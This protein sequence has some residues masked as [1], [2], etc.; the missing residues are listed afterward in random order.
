MAVRNMKDV[1]M[2]SNLKNNSLSGS[3]PDSL[4]N[5]NRLTYLDLSNNQ[6]SGQFPEWVHDL[7][8]LKILNLGQT[9]FSGEIPLVIGG[10]LNNLREF[11]KSLAGR[12]EKYAA[13][14]QSYKEF[15]RTHY[16]WMKRSKDLF[17]VDSIGSWNDIKFPENLEAYLKAEANHLTSIVF[18]KISRDPARIT[19][20]LKSSLKEPE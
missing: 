20:I 8:Y 14:R 12:H 4:R 15:F 7:S 13:L 11:F 16:P 17:W 2:Q 19:D 6:L 10:R 9:F 18:D 5:L 3:I 1:L